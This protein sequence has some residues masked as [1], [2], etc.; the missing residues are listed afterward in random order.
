MTVSAADFQATQVPLRS[1][2]YSP[3]VVHLF[4]AVLVAGWLIVDAVAALAQVGPP[5]RLG[6][7]GG[8]SS[9]T[10]IPSP[11]VPPPSAVPNFTP[12]TG[13]A[14][15]T[16]PPAATTTETVAP[17]IVIQQLDRVTPDAAGTSLA[18]GTGLDPAL[19]NGTPGD[20]AERLLALLPDAP[21]SH[22]LRDLQHRLLAASVPPPDGL[23]APGR[24][25]E[26]RADRL[27]AMGALDTLGEIAQSIPRSA[28]SGAIA[29]TLT[30]RAFAL[31][32]IEEACEYVSQFAEQAED[33]YWISASVPCDALRGEVGKVEFGVRLLAELG[34]PDA[35]LTALAQA[36]TTGASAGTVDLSGAQPAHLA[37]AA[38][39]RT[40]VD[41]TWSRSS[42]CRF[43]R[44]C[45]RGCR[46]PVRCASCGC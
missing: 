35:L 46:D 34:Q 44:S 30:D 19:W 24:F 36:Q 40:P 18:P 22:A 37:M 13:P 28:I 12:Q 5:I 9:D 43:G 15:S 3:R 11:S 39:S 23:S 6:P 14:P 27:L 8:K 29:R 2:G 17:G 20:V 33:R 32:A 10:A 25:L 4:A 45:A 41:R 31:G 16:V 26:L 42:L 7:P 1:K 38:L 21:A